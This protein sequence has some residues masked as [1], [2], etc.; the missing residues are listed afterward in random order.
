MTSKK[1]ILCLLVLAVLLVCAF[2]IGTFA[3]D[4]ATVAE[5]D[6]DGLSFTGNEGLHVSKPLTE[7]PRTYEA[8]VYLGED[9]PEKEGTIFGNYLDLSN[10]HMNFTLN[11]NGAP[12]IY[13][14][15]TYVKAERQTSITMSETV[16]G[17]GWTHIA[18]THEKN[19]GGDIF[20]C[21]INGVLSDTKTASYTYDFDAD[22]MEKIQFVSSFYV[23][24][25]YRPAS[26]EYYF[27]GNIKDVAIYS[28]VLT[29]EQIADSY[30]NGVN[31]AED[32]LMLYYE[33]TDASAT[34]TTED[35][36]GNGHTLKP[37]YHGR[38]IELD[39]SKYAY[40]F[41]VIGDTQKLVEYDAL[42]GTGYAADIFDWIVNNADAKKID[43]VIGLGDI[44]ESNIESEWTYASAQYDKLE[45]AGIPYSIT[46]GYSHDG[47][48]GEEFTT[49]FGNKA[50]FKNSSIVYHSGEDSATALAN[51]YQ[52]FKAGSTDY[53]ILSLGWSQRL[54][55]GVLEWADAAV[56]AHK[57]HKV[58]LITHY[59]LGIE[60]NVAEAAMNIHD[61]VVANNENVIM[62]LSGHIQYAS[63]IVRSNVIGNEG[64]T[65]KQFLINPQY[66][67]KKYEYDKS[68]FVAMFYFSEDGS[69]VDVEYISTSQSKK[70]GSD[71]LYGSMNE[72]SFKAN[73]VVSIETEYGIIPELYASAK[74]YPFVI[75]DSDKNWVGASDVLQ[76]VKSSTSAINIAKNHIA[77]NVWDGN[78]WGE[79]SKSVIIL[80]RRDVDMDSGEYYNNFSQIKGTVT[81]DLNGYTLATPESKCLFDTNLKAW[82]SQ[83]FPSEITIKNG[84][85]V[86]FNRE[87]V[88]FSAND[89]GIG[90]TFTYNFKDLNI[91]VKGSASKLAIR[92]KVSSTALSLYTY[93][94]YENCTINITEATASN[95]DLFDL[96][97]QYTNSIV[98]V[99]GGSIFADGTNYTVYANKATSYG[100]F[101][102]EES[103]LSGF[104]KLILP[105]DVAPTPEKFNDDIFFS[106]FDRNNDL[107]TY[108]LFFRVN[109]YGNVP[110]EYKSA[111][112]YPF[113]IFGND[114]SLI[115]VSD[116]FY[117]VKLA[118]SA[119]NIAKEY[120]A[121]NTWD[122]SSWGDS[123]RKAIVVMRR[124]VEM[125]ENELYNNLSQIR[126]EMI[127]DLGGYTL[128]APP[129]KVLFPTTL[130]AWTYVFPSEI[131]VKNGSIII[132]NRT[133]I[134]LSIA[135][136]GIGKMFTYNFENINFS[137][138][139][140]NA[141]FAAAYTSGAEHEVFPSI[142]FKNCSIDISASTAEHITLFNL[143]N[144]YINTQFKIE[145][146]SV[147]AGENTYSVYSQNGGKGK[148]TFSE[149]AEKGYM[150]IT[151]PYGVNPPSGSFNNDSLVFVKT[152]E[153]TDTITYSLVASGVE[154]YSTKVSLTL[155]A[156][157][158]VNVYV[159]KKGTTEFTFNGKNYETK[160]DFESLKSVTIDEVEYYIVSAE[161]P[162]CEAAKTLSLQAC[163]DFGERTATGTFTYSIPRYV[164]KIYNSEK[165]TNNQRIL[166]L[167]VL[168]YI[169]AA[170]EYFPDTNIEELQAINKILDK[171]YNL[172]SSVDKSGIS[173]V[174]S[175]GA[176]VGFV[177]DGTPK[178]RFY[179][180]D[181][182]NTSDYSFKIGTKTLTKA[183]EGVDQRGRYIDIVVYAYNLSKTFDCFVND[184]YGGSYNINSYYSYITTNEGTKDDEHL[185]TLVERLWKYS[186]S[187]E[188]YRREFLG[189]TDVAHE[190]YFITRKIEMST[191]SSKY[192]ER[193]CACG[194]SEKTMHTGI[195][196]GTKPVKVLFIGNS[197]TYYNDM[198]IMFLNIAKSSGI[199]LTVTSVTKGGWTLTQ[200][201]DPND[202][203]GAL[204][205]KAFADGD[206]DYVFLQGYAL[207][208]TIDKFEFYTG[209]RGVG[210]LA[211][212]DGAKVLLY[213]PISRPDY[214]EFYAEGGS[215]YGYTTDSF[216]RSSA[217]AYE[218]IAEEMGYTVS[219]AGTAFLYLYQNHRDEITLYASDNDH[220]SPESS[221]TF[222]LCH[223]ATLF[224]RSPIGIEYTAGFDA[225]TTLIL[226]TAAYNAVYGE[227][228][229]T[230]EYRTSSVG[231]GE[232]PEN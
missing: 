211:E 56:K 53:M 187:A 64:Q 232:Y 48:H 120:L 151:L 113:V 111:E 124:D 221:Y 28:D 40:S 14:H 205:A 102:F 15:D 9:A 100:S 132:C 158:V 185:I 213:H 85:L 153:T 95:I 204:V 155:D 103:S 216:T 96:G 194:Y 140:I 117:G 16:K 152:A 118:T 202:V 119:I 156:N 20:K 55:S 130:K 30:K 172:M 18:I 92:H 170:Y 175:I 81:I 27:K 97:N 2:T 82:S 182:R 179:I 71:V 45:N 104:T 217:A 74:D 72:F 178:F 32:S 157:L 26:N 98:T 4:N 196:D 226:Q 25:D 35:K 166:Y 1:R 192:D 131:T 41:A 66:M 58:I 137:S 224:G 201:M 17:K 229:V 174:P 121:V 70:A 167:D 139:G 89:N 75:F 223:F 165:T 109:D 128:S 129:S 173:L 210:A 86:I 57:D 177:L 65:V 63:N 8:V 37:V 3:Q 90:K 110:A 136:N 162:A 24:Q 21:Y 60:G 168:S 31:T 164:E 189:Y 39:M 125:A 144:S 79:S 115:N 38:D 220:P 67:D 76:G 145:G 11:S 146:V 135:E 91:Y 163:V 68:S 209:V 208:S 222:A 141:Q 228:I 42:N 108:H 133:L 59:Y 33:L 134:S 199:N 159:P 225:E 47:L 143:G 83:I 51:Y 114:G 46:W 69:T 197:S 6:N 126:G 212:A 231:M 50:N 43:R 200:F 147:T 80:M 49:Y 148:L 161:L 188:V 77:T 62:T 84:N 44:T 29:A 142:N 206:Y 106:E 73:E 88:Q 176:A 116:C 193:V 180:D 150:S 36:S 195:D 10:P 5:E 227:S 186:Q 54:A 34:G 101:S 198:P 190:H 61:N 23:G 19:D 191:T 105:T 169:K 149:G 171:D 219:K 184:E 203:G 160:E 107:V 122:G 207:H 78:S 230:E 218:A 94:N 138:T 215:G 13:V 7:M 112:D 214:H 52:T 154:K 127:I 93:V 181:D 183:G 12:K 22:A 87:I 123:P 99:K